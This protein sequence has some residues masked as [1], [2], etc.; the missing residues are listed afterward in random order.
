MNDS[1]RAPAGQREPFLDPSAL[2]AAPAFEPLGLVAGPA[3]LALCEAG[4]ALALAGG[5]MAF[6]HARFGDEFLSV[7][8]LRRRVT[9][10]GMSGDSG[11]GRCVEALTRPRPALAG[12]ALSGSGAR[13]RIMGVC[14]VTPDSFSDGGD[15]ADPIAAIA[16][17]RSLVDAGADIIDIGGES[18]RP[19]ATPVS[20]SE[21]LDRVLPVVEALAGDGAVVSIDTR[22]AEVMR[23]AT[24]AGAA[25]VNDVAALTEPGALAAVS[26]SDAAVILMHMRGNP[27]TM[28]VRPE[29]DDVVEEVFGWLADRVAACLAAGIDHDR[30]VIDPGFGFGKTVEHNAALLARLARFHGLGCGLAVGLSRKSFI[31]TWTGETDAKARMPG[32]L[33]GAV[34]VAAQGAQVIRVHDVTETRAALSVWR[35]SVGLTV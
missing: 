12:L 2:S 33:A 26:E 10:A 15:H 7:P 35:R 24:A 8:E 32:S 1:Q 18:T 6:T 22:H 27:E 19:G 30:I 11:P 20:R 9:Q 14:N 16:F 4:S 5:A 17:A 13:A 28:Q 3:A 29:Y 25:I 21:E 23:A 34:A 31:G